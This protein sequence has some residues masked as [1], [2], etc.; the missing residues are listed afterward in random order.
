[1][2]LLLVT[3]A[4]GLREAADT[5]TRFGNMFLLSL[6]KNFKLL[7][8]PSLVVIVKFEFL[9]GLVIGEESVPRLSS[10]YY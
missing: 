10:R 8:L 1:M 4:V 3:P 2:V 6:W 7:G 9:L 5:G